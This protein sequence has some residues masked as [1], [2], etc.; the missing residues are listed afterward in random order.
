MFSG[1]LLIT[2]P[3]PYIINTTGIHRVL[4]SPG[5]VCVYTICVCMYHICVYTHTQAH[6]YTFNNV[7]KKKQLS[8][9]L[10]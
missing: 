5:I 6:I 9:F 4:T 10:R 2:I 7:M 8:P 3:F 1:L